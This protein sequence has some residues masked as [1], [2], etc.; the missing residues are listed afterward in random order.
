MGIGVRMRMNLKTRE[1]EFKEDGQEYSQ[2]IKMLG[3][4]WLEAMCF[5]CYQEVISYNGKWGRMFELML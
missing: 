1:L 2:V 5:W 3:N 4:G